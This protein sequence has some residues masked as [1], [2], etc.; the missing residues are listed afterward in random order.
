MKGRSIELNEIAFQYPDEMP[1]LLTALEIVQTSAGAAL[2]PYETPMQLRAGSIFDITLWNCIASY[3]PTALDFLTRQRP[4]VKVHHDIIEKHGNSETR[5][6]C[7]VYA[8]VMV[9]DYLIP[10]TSESE[11]VIELFESFGLNI[12]LAHINEDVIECNG[13]IQCLRHVAHRYGYVPHIMASIIASQSIQFLMNDGFNDQGQLTSFGECTA[14]CRSFADYTG[15]KPVNNPYKNDP[16]FEHRWA[17]LSE[18]NG[19]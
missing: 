18:D 6:L 19:L 13:K 15:Y 17:P 9:M 11:I 12:S 7:I 4:A 10:L 1:D 16:K 14:N 5:M 8:S 2:R 3:H